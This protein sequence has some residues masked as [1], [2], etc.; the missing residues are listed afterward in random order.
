MASESPVVAVAPPLRGR[1]AVRLLQGIGSF[2]ASLAATFVGLTAV[3]FFI[4]RLTRIDPV[5]AVVG[6]KA[7][8][9]A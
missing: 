5:L 1:F 3:T 8:K 4:S 9:G 7:T 6:D 2:V